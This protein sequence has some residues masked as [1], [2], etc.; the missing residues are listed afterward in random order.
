[1]PIQ[2]HR[3]CGPL[4]NFV[5]ML[6]RLE[7]DE[8]SGANT[9]E[10][11]VPDGS[12][13]LVINLWEDSARTFDFDG[14]AEPRK[15][16][17]AIFSGPHSSPFV[18]PATSNRCLIGA[19]FVAGGAFPFLAMPL[20]ELRNEHVELEALFGN[21]AG[22]L[23]GELLSLET[24]AQQ[25]AVLESFLLRQLVKSRAHHRAV[26]FAL[27]RFGSSDQ[28]PHRIEELRK[29]AGL[30][31]RRFS[32]V[33]SEQVGLT[34]KLFARLNRFQRAVRLLPQAR[35][36][37]WGEIVFAAGYYDQAHLIHEFQSVS[38]VTPMEYV[39][40]QTDRWN[41]LANRV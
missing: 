29:D 21:G 40:R 31:G 20:E 19:H 27:Q 39:S 5:A 22:E 15:F 35:E 26:V 32:R 34:P 2:F 38:G 13:E 11:I 37:N 30:S 7:G 8:R 14:I 16:G 17:G 36:I 10:T 4:R 23:R 28:P 24:A 3:P 41:H 33:F 1:M 12:A 25:F 6:W 18:I 9:M